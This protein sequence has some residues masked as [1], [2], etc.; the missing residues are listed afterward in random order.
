MGRVAQSLP[1]DQLQRSIVKALRLEHNWSHDVS[2]IRRC[3]TLPLQDDGLILKMQ[4]VTPNCLVYLS[5]SQ[6]SVWNI[7]HTDY[8]V[9]SLKTNHAVMF[10]A[11][12][13]RE[14]EVVIAVVEYD[15][16]GDLPTRRE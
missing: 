7:G 1:S 5:R 14:S 9:A 4:L 8:L 6:I 2:Y 12:V 3:R 13:Q 10:S 16:R 15:D 11:A